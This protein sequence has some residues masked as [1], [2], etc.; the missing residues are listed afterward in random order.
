MKKQPNLGCADVKLVSCRPAM[1]ALSMSKLQSLMVKTDKKLPFQIFFVPAQKSQS[2]SKTKK[3][4]DIFFLLNELEQKISESFEKIFRL[5][6]DLNDFLSRSF[7]LFIVWW[8][9]TVFFLVLERA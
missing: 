7:N 9:S 2:R 1:Q 8:H 4:R 5:F 3:L 6:G